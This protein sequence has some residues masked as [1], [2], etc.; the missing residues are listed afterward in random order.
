MYKGVQHQAL[1]LALLDNFRIVAYLF[2]ALSPFVFLMKR[3]QIVAPAAG[4]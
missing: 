4:H 2:F 1:L 3:P